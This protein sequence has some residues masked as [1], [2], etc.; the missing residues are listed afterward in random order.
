MARYPKAAWRPL[1]ENA[2]QGPNRP[3]LFIV[4]TMVGW[5]NG[6][7]QWF[8]RE[9][10]R[11]ESHFGIAMEAHQELPIRQWM[12]TDVRA[13]TNWDA[14][15]ISITVECEDRG[16]PSTPL[17]EFQIDSLVDLGEWCLRKYPAIVPR[18]AN[19]PFSAG[20]GYHQMY[21]EWNRSNHNCP[22]V[23]RRW[24]LIQIVFPRIIERVAKVRT[25]RLSGKDR[26]DT[27]F[28][29]ARTRFSAPWETVVLVADGS[30]EHKLAAELD[31]PV[32]L[33]TK[34][35]LPPATV[36]ALKHFKP[37]QIIVLGGPAVISAEVERRAQAVAS[38]A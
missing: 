25:V 38:G 13:D 9:D 28:Q 2:T 34:N 15:G 36:E 23:T 20:L 29:I 6:S 37:T 5:N 26:F 18:T 22:G 7:E 30:A 1:P 3:R 33:C 21:P 27:A 4:H 31:A 19:G 17:T 12:D 8:R 10:V 11:S 32:L 16:D 24:Q 35:D 14:N